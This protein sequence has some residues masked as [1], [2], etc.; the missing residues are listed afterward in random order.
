MVVAL[1]G[2][3]GPWSDH[4]RKYNHGPLKDG[5]TRTGREVP[6]DQEYALSCKMFDAH[7]NSHIV[8][9]LTENGVSVSHE[10]VLGG[11]VISL[12]DTYLGE[13]GF[14]ALLPLL[15]RSTS[16]VDLDASN[17]GLRNEAVLHLVDLLLR[18]K[19]AVRP[20]RLNLSRNPISEGAGR[21][22]LELATIHPQVDFID[23]SFTRIPRRTMAKIRVQLDLANE[24]RGPSMSRQTSN[25]R[26]S[27]SSTSRPGSR[28]GSRSSILS[29]PFVSDEELSPK[30]D[31]HD[32]WGSPSSPRVALQRPRPEPLVGQDYPV[33]G[34]TQ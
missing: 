14:I 28:T 19:H 10:D 6:I 16:W 32:D 8:Q 30:S 1:N 23:V 9:N 25:A 5:Y 27:R 31:A 17:N 13:R 33:S 29:N 12:R 20:I 22:L 11:D 18:P 3:T 26:R 4:P 21:A 15:D 24:R 2:Y 7:P 34:G